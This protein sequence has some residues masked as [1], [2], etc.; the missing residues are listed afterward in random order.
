MLGRVKLD[1]TLLTCDKGTFNQI[2]A[3]RRKQTLVT[4]VRHVHYHSATSIPV[5][6]NPLAT[7]KLTKPR[8][9]VIMPRNQT[10][11]AQTFHRDEL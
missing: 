2:T 10:I 1:N 6:A 9:S 11:S 7:P 5:D 8:S 4:V 3:R